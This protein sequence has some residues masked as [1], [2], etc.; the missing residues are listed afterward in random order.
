MKT[1]GDTGVV[2]SQIADSVS[3]RNSVQCRERW[4]NVISGKH[5]IRPWTSEDTEKLL[6]YGRTQLEQ[7]T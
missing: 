3:T 4:R 5:L 6:D 1:Y 2:W 7:G